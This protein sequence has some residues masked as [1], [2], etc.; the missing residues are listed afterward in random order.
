MKLLFLELITNSRIRPRQI[1]EIIGNVHMPKGMTS[2]VYRWTNLLNGMVYVGM[3]KETIKAYWTSSTDKDFRKKLTDPNSSWELEILYWGS[4]SECKQFEHEILKENDAKN[5]PLYYNKSN[6]TPG[7]KKCDL[8]S[9]KLL[10]EDL[11]AIRQNIAD[12]E[13][14][15][16]NKDYI[17]E[18]K[19]VSELYKM[20]R[21]Q[22]RANEYDSD[23]LNKL[24][25]KFRLNLGNPHHVILLQNRKWKS[26]DGKTTTK[27]WV[28]I[29][30]NH[31]IKA[32]YDTLP[33]SDLPVI[34]LPPEIHENY[35]DVEIRLLGNELNRDRSVSAPFTKEDAIKECLDLHKAGNSYRTIDNAAR[36]I[37]LGLVEGHVDNV[38]VK[39]DK[40]INDKKMVKSG[41]V[42]MNW[43]GSLDNYHT[44]LLNKHKE[45]ILDVD[46]NTL[47]V[48]PYAG[49]A[50]KM[51]NIYKIKHI[52]L[53][54]LFHQLDKML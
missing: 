45:R 53:V 5:N 26:E 36:L 48:G 32:C 23:N 43:R 54:L 46:G 20:D 16:I 37:D 22:T 52:Q 34:I 13:Y 25:S 51:K 30:G 18:P 21:I 1:K 41:K 50:M 49:S 35:T 38:F 27:V 11:D 7:T 3:H 40:I 33:Y 31:T 42:V 28:V 8:N 47:I 39:V 14:K 29:S 9:I 19:P 44:T 15:I 17:G 6:G 4:V 2:T 10:R 12:H 24:K